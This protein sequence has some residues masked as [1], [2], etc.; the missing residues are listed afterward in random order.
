MDEV[1]D[2]IWA[3]LARYLSG[4]VTTS[5]C[6]IV[7]TLLSENVELKKFYDQMRTDY[8]M[9]EPTVHEVASQVFAKL[10]ARIKKSNRSGN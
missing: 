2:E 5:E 6:L 4:E 8:L 1:R 3:L 7:E 9:Q 10:D